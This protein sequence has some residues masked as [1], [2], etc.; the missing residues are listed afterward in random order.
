MGFEK[1]EVGYWN[2]GWNG[3]AWDD[4]KKKN[5]E[6][7][8]G[9]GNQMG[10][11]IKAME[12]TECHIVFCTGT[13]DAADKLDNIQLNQNDTAERLG[14]GKYEYNG[15]TYSVFWARDKPRKRRFPGGICVI[16]KKQLLGSENNQVNVVDV[17]PTQSERIN[18]KG[19]FDITK[20]RIF[21]VEVLSHLGKMVFICCYGIP[22]TSEDDAEVDQKDQDALNFFRELNRVI[23]EVR[24][25]ERA[26]KLVAVLGDLN[27]QIPEDDVKKLAK[28]IK[29]PEDKINTFAN[30]GCR[31]KRKNSFLKLCEDWKLAIA[32]VLLPDCSPTFEKEHTSVGWNNHFAMGWVKPKENDA[33]IKDN[34]FEDN[35]TAG[36]KILDPNGNGIC[37]NVRV[38]DKK[39]PA[40]KENYQF[41]HVAS[42]DL[43][44]QPTEWL[45]DLPI[46]FPS[47]CRP[48][49][50]SNRQSISSA[51]FITCSIFEQVKS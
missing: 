19:Q 49:C 14:S 16:W 38:T 4:K 11:V 40:A 31:D 41:L 28:E 25:P 24:K 26:I 51:V 8:H 39:M 15:K 7:W 33:W 29:W 43:E 10:D 35:D 12:E 13:Q 17:T 45:I 27:V 1:L 21:T 37:T 6:K 36:L 22:E 2:V 30:S 23:D 44:T 34:D 9:I 3:M 20:H 48:N 46:D 47:N 32:S 18:K 42:L 50:Q 5:E